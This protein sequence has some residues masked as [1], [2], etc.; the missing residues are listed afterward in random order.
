MAEVRVLSFCVFHTAVAKMLV[1]VSRM[2]A[3]FVVK[4]EIGNFFED[5]FEWLS[6]AE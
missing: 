1:Q 2:M 3:I 4:V 5:T 6:S